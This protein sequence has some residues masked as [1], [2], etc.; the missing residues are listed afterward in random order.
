MQGEQVQVQDEGSIL[1]VSGPQ[2][3]YVIP[4]KG[5]RGGRS[6]RRSGWGGCVTRGPGHRMQAASEMDRPVNRRDGFLLGPGHNP[7]LF[8][9]AAPSTLTP[10]LGVFHIEKSYTHWS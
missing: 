6:R 1:V 5:Q 2:R 3:P 4:H 9:A 10:G 7:L 8:P